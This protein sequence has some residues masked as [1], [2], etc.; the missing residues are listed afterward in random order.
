MQEIAC[1]HMLTLVFMRKIHA[2]QT[3][4]KTTEGRT[5]KHVSEEVFFLA[6]LLLLAFGGF[7]CFPV[8]NSAALFAAVY[9]HNY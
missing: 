9:S 1:A 7:V 3:V 5:G 4:N 8:L 6:I 2:E